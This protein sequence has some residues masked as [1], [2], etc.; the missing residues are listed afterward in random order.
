VV[1]RDILAKWNLVVVTTTN[2]NEQSSILDRPWSTLSGG[3]SQ[4]ILLA[5]V[6]TTIIISQK[7]NTILVLDE[8][9]SGLDKETQILVERMLQEYLQNGQLGAI[10]M[11]THS[12]EQL[13]RF[14][15]HQFKL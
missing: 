4:R 1:L 10:L 2:N 8:A 12:D 13:Q 3:E 15:T 9:I 7:N 5:I 6:M 14:C 11:V